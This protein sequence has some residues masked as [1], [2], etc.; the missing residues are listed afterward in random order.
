[1][2]DEPVTS[3]AAKLTGLKQSLIVNLTGTFAATA[4]DRKAADRGYESRAERNDSS[5]SARPRPSGLTTPAATTATRL[6]F[7]I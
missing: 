5:V 7:T 3:P 1:M 6:F 4:I 2:R